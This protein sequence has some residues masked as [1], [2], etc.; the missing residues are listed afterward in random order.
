MNPDNI[1][2]ETLNRILRKMEELTGTPEIP[3]GKKEQPLGQTSG[4]PQSTQPANGTA[5]SGGKF[6]SDD[7]INEKDA[8]ETE[9]ETEKPKKDFDKKKIVFN[10]ASREAG[11]GQP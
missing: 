9:N 5:T 8:N 6:D 2:Q 4:I 7:K 3:K 1:M 10:R 11:P